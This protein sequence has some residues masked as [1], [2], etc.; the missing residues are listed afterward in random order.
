[1][2]RVRLSSLCH[3]DVLLETAQLVHDWSYLEAEGGMSDLLKRLMGLLPADLDEYLLSSVQLLLGHIKLNLAKFN[4]AKDLFIS[5]E[6]IRVRFYTL[7][8]VP[9]AEAKEV[10]T[11]I[12]VRFQ[13][14]L[15]F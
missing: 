10:R 13:D 7:E 4:D 6:V 1:V 8:S 14:R 5:C 11:I 9:V 12:W 2:A 3:G 15:K